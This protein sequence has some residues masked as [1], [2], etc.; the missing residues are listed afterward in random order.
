VY[1]PDDGDYPGFDL[2]GELDCTSQLMGSS[3]LLGDQATWY[4]SNDRRVNYAYHSDDA[5][6][7]ASFVQ[8]NIINRGVLTLTETYVAK[9][10]DLD[11]GCSIDDYV[12]TEVN[13]GLVYGYNADL[14]DENCAGELGYG[15]QVAALGIK[16]LAGP[17]AD[18]DGIDNPLTTDL[19]EM[20]TLDGIAYASQGQGYGDGI[21]DNER[22]GLRGTLFYS[23]NDQTPTPG[24]NGSPDTAPD[25]YNYIT[26]KWRNG[27]PVTYGGDGISSGT[28]ETK[29]MYPGDSDPLGVGTA[30]ELPYPGTRGSKRAH[31]CLCLGKGRDGR[32]QR[33]A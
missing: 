21:V 5:L 26:N 17:A 7:D 24:I 20:E 29:Y 1:S 32:D 33:F 16:M 9:W 23:R 4:V 8:Y 28:I 6:N 12:G 27:S 13:K 10:A 25:Y 30:G 2:S 11:L 19:E 15:N 14:N 31:L 18:N 3:F 22:L